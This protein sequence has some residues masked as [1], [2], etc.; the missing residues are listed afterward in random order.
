VRWGDE[1]FGLKFLSSWLRWHT[2]GIPA[3]Q[4]LR[5]EDQEFE[6]SMSSTGSS[7]PVWARL[8][9]SKT[10]QNKNNNK[11]LKRCTSVIYGEM[12][13]RKLMRI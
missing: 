11:N 12:S 1:S 9:L 4:R 13:G 5:Q 7:Q 10:K 6:I 2:S 3:F 8:C